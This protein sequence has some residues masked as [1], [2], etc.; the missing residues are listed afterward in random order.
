MQSILFRDDTCQASDS[1]FELCDL[2]V[3]GKYCQQK[4]CK[5]SVTVF[6]LGIFD[7]WSTHRN[8]QDCFVLCGVHFDKLNVR[9]FWAFDF[10]ETKRNCELT[11]HAGK[12]LSWSSFSKIEQ[13]FHRTSPCS[14]YDASKCLRDRKRKREHSRSDS[15]FHGNQLSAIFFGRNRGS[16]LR[17]QSDWHDLSSFRIV[18]SLQK[19][20]IPSSNNGIWGSINE[21][22]NAGFVWILHVLQC[23][24]LRTYQKSTICTKENLLAYPVCVTLC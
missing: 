24:S 23:S 14:A 13:Y 5:V 20:G 22:I 12:L 2:S 17:I 9:K 6:I 15:I 3:D 10:V 16:C 4:F 18:L 1:A 7:N 21:Q 8:Q 19:A 11:N